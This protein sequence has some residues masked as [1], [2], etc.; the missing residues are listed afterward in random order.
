MFIDLFVIVSG[1][2]VTLLPTMGTL[3]VGLKQNRVMKT[4]YKG[5]MA[6]AALAAVS[7][8]IPAMSSALN[9]DKLL[10][11]ERLQPQKSVPSQ[12]MAIRKAAPAGTPYWQTATSIYNGD[13]QTDLV[14]GVTREFGTHIE[15]EGETAR[16]Y[17]L[18]DI[19]YSNYFEIDEEYVV[20]G[21]YNERY[22]TITISGTDYETSRPLSEYV[23]LADI[24]S[25]DDDM[26]YTI[27]LIAGDV[28][29]RGNVSTQD[30]LVFNVSDDLTTITPKT[31][32]GAYAFTKDGQGKAFLDYYKTSSLVKA[33]ADPKLRANVSDIT[34]KGQF[35][36]TGMPVKEQFNI[37]NTGASVSPYTVT[38][39]STWLKVTPVEGNI[40]GCS[41][42]SFAVTFT[43]GEAGM[44]NGNITVE[45]SGQKLEI[46]VGVEV[47]EA[48]DYTKIVRAGSDPIE[49]EM[50]PVYPFV[51]SEVNG[52]TV[53][54]S[55]NN[56]AGDN[57]ESWFKCN[58]DVPEGKSAVFSWQAIQEAQQPNGLFVLLDGEWVKY[59]MYR[60]NTEPYDMS[61]AIALTQGKHEIVFDNM[62]SLDWSIYDVF[63]RSYVWDLNYKLID[64]KD[65]NAVLVKDNVDFGE[66]YFDKL[67]VEMQS[68]VTVLNVGKNPL[69]ILSISSDSNFGGTVPEMTAP[70]GGEI[71]VPLT[72][73]ASAVGEDTGVVT[74]HTSGGDLKVNCI[75]H[76]TVLPYDYSFL[77]KEGDF[78]FNTDA[79]WPFKPN[80]KGT[81]V[82][83]S[84]SKADIN[85][86]T[87]CWLEASFEVPEG[88]F[89]HISWDAI[90]DSEDLFVFMGTPSVI[91]G[92]LF[93][94]DG[95]NEVMVGGVGAHCASSDLYSN[96]DLTF[97]PGRHTVK[98]NYKKKSN[99]EDEVF[100]S[101]C[102]KLF[103]IALKL[104][105]SK[106]GEG[107]LAMKNAEYTNEVYAGTTAYLYT[108]LHNYSSE[109]PEL[110]SSECDGP[111]KAVSLGVED[112]N[113]SLAIEFTPEK[114]GSY[115]SD[116]VI[117]TNIGDYTLPC[118]GKGMAPELGKA[119]YFEGFE[120]DFG[121]DWIMMDGDG[122]DNF[123]KP[124]TKLPDAFV[125]N[126][127]APYDGTGL[128]YVSYFD[129]ET[130][131]YYDVV[132]T[133][134]LTPV[135]SVPENGKTTLRFMVKGFT[136]GSQT[137]DI[138][139]GEGEDPIG[140]ASV[141]K[142][143]VDSGSS[144]W[145]AYTFDL[146]E[147]AGKN[148]HIAFHA[149]SDIGQYFALDNVL[150]ASTAESSVIMPE[151]DDD[152]TVEYY[153][154][155]GLRH[156][157]PVKGL[158]IIVTRHGDGTSTTRKEWIK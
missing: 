141:G 66:T 144:A 2:I 94:I 36:A 83:N 139:A 42:L 136:Y 51:I 100:G 19:N 63:Q 125:K 119:I 90:N 29:D 60:P 86:I 78:S 140:Y 116:L 54:E 9:A 108:T 132:D 52:I 106:E 111:F 122:K 21:V 113:L 135:I 74:I 75:G 98:F 37:M 124:S 14:N 102:L 53:A 147:L 76:A 22:G 31:G 59:E 120:Y 10:T 44:F 32:F 105:D 107:E 121:N 103:E 46:P 50:S 4:I 93:T 137:L 33:Q 87:F 138:L 117:K 151:T 101:D 65:D 48:P 28:D 30:K 85:G 38:T 153:A 128:M 17:G 70:A 56:G 73:K 55:I 123:W 130:G 39:S 15:I 157:H 134:A 145:K 26:S 96:I 142:V 118:S 126:D 71:T 91:S 1:L 109:T 72:W 133:Y 149:G 146:G 79:E 20:E 49:F 92:T 47:R 99:R 154:P 158:N 43:P 61:G 34:F 45:G 5:I 64:A 23:K 81:Y 35:V 13:G 67:S 115:S 148:I 3:P 40:E 25:P 18:V 104:T 97:R 88:K 27:V 89:G 127:M 68:E 110:L 156:D 7:M 24:Y 114:E 131:T 12:K 129:P 150:V 41:T 82:Y 16:I 58:V 11:A 62:I 112:G 95:L 155:D 8:A 84:T 143:T 6:T 77:V 80:D 69:K 152:C 57:T